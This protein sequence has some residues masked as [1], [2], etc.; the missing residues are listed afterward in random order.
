MAGEASLFIDL[1][2]LVFIPGIRMALPRAMAGFTLDIFQDIRRAWGFIKTCGVAGK[3]GEILC[4][5][6][7]SPKAGMNHSLI[8]SP[9]GD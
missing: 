6:S 9:K 5:S 2:I 4:P 3:T 7:A 8:K 1:G